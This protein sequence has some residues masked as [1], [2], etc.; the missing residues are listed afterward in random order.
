[1]AGTIG[2]FSLGIRSIRAIRKYFATF[3]SINWAE[4]RQHDFKTYKLNSMDLQKPRYK[5]QLFSP[6]VPPRHSC[7][8][9]LWYLGV[10]TFV[11][12]LPLLQPSSRA[13]I[14]SYIPFCSEA[15]RRVMPLL[16]QLFKISPRVVPS[17]ILREAGNVAYR[18]QIFTTH[19][20]R[21]AQK[22]GHH[23]AKI[24]RHC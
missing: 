21:Q 10:L 6:L 4:S 22:K 7:Y 15:R 13:H 3:F 16:P 1:M 14:T 12:H 23:S 17:S 11:S 8:P 9:R 20:C 2:H 18:T 19:P 5:L 24:E